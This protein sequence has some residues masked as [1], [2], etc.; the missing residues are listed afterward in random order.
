MKFEFQQVMGKS[1]FKPWSKWSPGDFLVGKY[2]S[3]SVDKFDKP[4][5]KV[6]VIEAQFDEG[7][8]PNAG[9]YFT[10]NANG[11]LN[12]AM[13]SVKEGDII[14]VIYKGEET[15]SKGKYAGKKFHAL[16]VLAA[17]STPTV[18]ESSEDDLI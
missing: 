4:N 3:Q 15:V 18:T 10:L 9:E 11:S 13:E 17:K 8:H 16:E 2:V 5:Y 7:D 6:E 12:K 14:K 1:A